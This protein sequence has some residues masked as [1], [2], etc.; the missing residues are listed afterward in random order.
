MNRG[1][2]TAHITHLLPG[3]AADTLDA[4][5]RKSVQ[6]HLTACPECQAEWLAW[7]VI[8]DAVRATFGEPVRVED[9]PMAGIWR[10]IDGAAESAGI[11]PVRPVVAPLPI[12]PIPI[13]SPV[14]PQRRGRS[15]LAHLATAALIVLTLAGSLLAFGWRPW[16]QERAVILPAVIATPATP[17]PIQRER[18]I[19][20][21][22]I[23]LPNGPATIYAVVTDVE[24]GVFA[25][26]DGQVGTFVYWVERGTVEI[27]HSGIEQ[28]VSA[29]EQ[30]GA[31]ID[32]EA[33][34]GNVGDEPARVIEVDVLD[35]V[36]TSSL[37]ATY[38]SKFSDPERGSD[39]FP[40]SAGVNLSGG[41]GRVIL[42]R[43][44]LPPGAALQ[45]YTQP[46]HG[47]VGI[48]TGRLG[49]TLKGDRLPFRWDPGE[50]RTYGVM[51]SL[52]GIPPGTEITLR[53]PGD[54]PLELYLLELI[55]GEAAPGTPT[56]ITTATEGIVYETLL[57][58]EAPALPAGQEMIAIDRWRLTPSQAQL[59]LPAHEGAVEVIVDAGEV[60]VRVDGSERR[61]DAGQAI[62][63]TN[64]EFALRAVGTDRAIAYVVYV[65]PELVG[66]GAN[67]L[68]ISGDPLVHSSDKVISASVDDFPG[69]A[70]R[71]ILQE[72]TLPPGSALPPSQ[73]SRLVA[74]QVGAGE[75]G[76]TLDGD[77]LPYRWKPGTER[78]IFP[79]GREPIPFLAPGT[80]MLMRNAGDEPLV[81]YRFELIPGEQTQSSIATPQSEPP[82]PP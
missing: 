30:W 22:D 13:Q 24:P 63:V 35:S 40:I 34:L 60:A 51:E 3:Y 23:A 41:T 36:A 81:L 37:D 66:F 45:P 53:N 9:D 78:R 46:A 4:S 76:L 56:T 72:I 32:G 8:G 2:Q 74:I 27:F 69:G 68:W 48:A 18:L 77:R 59:V 6:V 19:D 44:T 71:L 80:T 43:V 17:E 28:V 1:T 52:P 82:P 65:T 7:R 50:E 26:L 55:P 12:G 62:A 20:A 39:F 54:G 25:A 75:L 49:M 29:G 64:R 14:P 58:T 67:R 70:A 57:D 31:P 47:W 33:R 11:P 21:A 79:F 16:Q 5:D 38:A 42:D 15:L 61:L 10:R 73:A